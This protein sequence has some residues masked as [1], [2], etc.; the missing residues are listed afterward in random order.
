MTYVCTHKYAKEKYLS[1]VYNN[2]LF[3]F[4]EKSTARIFYYI[5]ITL[6]SIR[7]RMFTT[8]AFLCVFEQ[9]LGTT[10]SEL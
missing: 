1:R 3:V 9:A 7:I 6:S 8:L 10:L 5:F 2:D 4:V